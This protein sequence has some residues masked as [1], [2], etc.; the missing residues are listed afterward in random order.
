MLSG[1]GVHLG[2]T[3]TAMAGRAKKDA[4]LGLGGQQRTQ[5]REAAVVFCFALN[6]CMPCIHVYVLH[7]RVW[8]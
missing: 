4:W 3:C 1:A 2:S 5:V 6:V 7:V 8:V